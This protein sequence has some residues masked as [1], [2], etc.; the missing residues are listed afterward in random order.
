M[1][2]FLG[3]PPIIWCVIA[4]IT[5]LAN[6]R[7]RGLNHC[8]KIHFRLYRPVKVVWRSLG[9]QHCSA[10]YIIDF[11]GVISRIVLLRTR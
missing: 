7:A 1:H 11:F 8:T 6:H 10:G 4:A 3:V 9:L 5:Y 2:G